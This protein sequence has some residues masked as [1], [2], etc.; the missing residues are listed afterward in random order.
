MKIFSKYWI[1]G[2]EIISTKEIIGCYYYYYY[3]FL[4]FIYLFK[5]NYYFINIYTVLIFYIK[6]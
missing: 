4:L 6:L 3:F 5:F 2:I 1:M